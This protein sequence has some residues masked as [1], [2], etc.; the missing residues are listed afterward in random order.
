MKFIVKNKEATKIVNIAQKRLLRPRPTPFS[1]PVSLSYDSFRKLMACC[2]F[3]MAQHALTCILYRIVSYRN[4]VCRRFRPI[5]R[6][7][8]GWRVTD[9]RRYDRSVP[10][11]MEMSESRAAKASFWPLNASSH[12][13]SSREQ[14]TLRC[15]DPIAAFRTSVR[16]KGRT[17]WARK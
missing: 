5:R 1:F 13:I 3:L 16:N 7:R 2:P 12:R 14:D 17:G 4:T 6:L 11:V 10:V 15:V 9:A 8:R